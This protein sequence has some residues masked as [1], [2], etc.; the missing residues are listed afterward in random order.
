MAK[1]YLKLGNSFYGFESPFGGFDIA[2]GRFSNNRFGNEQIEIAA[3]V[4]PSISSSFFMSRRNKLRTSPCCKIANNCRFDVNTRFHNH[5][6]TLVAN[7]KA[8]RPPSEAREQG[9]HKILTRVTLFKS[10]HSF[11]KG[12]PLRS[13]GALGYSVAN[14]LFLNFLR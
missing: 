6:I 14:I 5:I 4:V 9:F 1:H 11:K 8:H 3:T 12:R 7:G 2:G 10:C 13:S